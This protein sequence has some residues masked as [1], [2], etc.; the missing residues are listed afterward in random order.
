MLINE[1]GLS[2]A[3]V[4]ILAPKEDWICDRFANEF[5]QAF[6][7][8]IASNPDDA[9]VIWLLADWC[10]DQLP[11]ELL[12]RKRVLT[13][14]HHIY[15]EK[16]LD[17]EQARFRHRDSITHLYHVPCNITKNVVS[18]FSTRPI[19]SC[20]FWLN[21]AFWVRLGTCHE[22]RRRYE[23]PDNAYLV[24]SFQRDTEG[25]D[26]ASPKLEKGPD[27]LCDALEKMW[28]SDK[29]LHVVLAGWRRQYVL[30]RLKTAGVP[31]TYF[32]RPS[33]VVIRDLY[34]SLDLYVVA[35]RVE[36][37]PMAITECAALEV[38]IV[39]TPVG[40]APEI[41]A[42][43]SV[44]FDITTLAS[45]V[46][47]AKANVEKIMSPAGFEPFVNILKRISQ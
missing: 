29:S 18:R 36:G 41:L 34:C 6:P 4:F 5:S 33:A 20:P 39:S 19:V 22:M 38:P 44:G 43:E 1:H 25:V 30:N 12:K 16:F 17:R 26:L 10:Y 2:N 46:A 27:I 3:S 7:S 23:L 35:A 47:V 24:G 42:P 15:H 37:G 32:E 13:S 21:S 9:K 11:Y 8:L 40:Q 28:A 14:I 45:N 31:F